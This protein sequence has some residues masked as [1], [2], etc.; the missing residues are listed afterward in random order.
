[1]R[2]SHVAMAL[3]FLFITAIVMTCRLTVMMCR[4]FVMEC[5]VSMMGCEAA[6]A[7]DFCHVFAISTYLLTPL[8]TS[9][10]CFLRCKLM[11]VSAF[12]GGLSAHAGDFALLFFIHCSKTSRLGLSSQCDPPVIEVL[13]SFGPDTHI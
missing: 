3:A 5:G 1:M 2:V 4:I 6:F 9:F 13:K 10:R 8:A 12:V 11:G 7:T